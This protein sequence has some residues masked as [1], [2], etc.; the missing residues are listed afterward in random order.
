VGYVFL[1]EIIS[2]NSSSAI[3]V[4]SLKPNA[5]PEWQ[6]RNVERQQVIDGFLFTQGACYPYLYAET[7]L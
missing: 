5:A 2:T 7:L 6:A 1:L 3:V 4:H